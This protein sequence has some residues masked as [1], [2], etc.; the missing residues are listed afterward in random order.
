MSM[1]TLL[2]VPSFEDSTVVLPA[3]G[4]GPGNWV[5]ASSVVLV[6][7]VFW[8]AYRVRR[9]LAV[10]RGVATVVARSHDG[11]HFESVAELRR[12]TFG[13][14]SFERPA[15][16]P[17][18]EGGWRLYVSCATPRSKH[19]WIG[20]VDAATPEQLADGERHVVL[21]G[22]DT[23]AFKDP[24]IVADETGWR[25]WV[26]RHPLDVQGAE[27]RMSTWYATSGDG[28]DWNFERE[29][30]APRSGQ[31]DARGARVTAVLSAEPLTVLYDGRA[32]AEQ[33]WFETTGV[34]VESDGLLLSVSDTP[35]A[36]SPEGDGALRYANVVALPDGSTRYYFEAA[37]ADGAH[38]LRTLVVP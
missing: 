25:M 13:A 7:D 28:L 5:G 30:L 18:P 1:S 11:V 17:R 36:S 38:D 2:T 22:D 6:D 26:C 24:V 8:L 33:N 10:G 4:N 15:L 19:W 37:R 12:E 29:V 31:W 20:A 3:P 16:L 34:A 14:E 32:S 35:A 23:V 27:D 21:A 9:P